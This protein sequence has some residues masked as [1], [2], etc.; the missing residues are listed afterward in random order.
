M[1]Q[2]AAWL[3]VMVRFEIWR[4]TEEQMQKAKRIS[5]VEK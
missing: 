3:N 2:N 1:D 5:T 4:F